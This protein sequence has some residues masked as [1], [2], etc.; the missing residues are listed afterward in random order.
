M[1]TKH[2]QKKIAALFAELMD[3]PR[4]RFPEAGGS[5]DAPNLK[6]VYVIY[7]PARRVLHVGST[8]QPAGGIRQRAAGSHPGSIVLRAEVVFASGAK[9]AA[10]AWA[11]PISVFGGRQPAPAG[12]VR[13]AGDWSP[14]SGPYRARAEIGS[15]DLQLD[16]S[17]GMH[18][19]APSTIPTN[20]FAKR[21]RCIAHRTD[22]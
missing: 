10:T 12:A 4:Q 9:G 13:S 22:R 5:I 15:S 18:A 16:R 11:S 3:E 19:P 17:A 6:G 20:S 14:L 7:S 8:P 1:N 2:E 21:L